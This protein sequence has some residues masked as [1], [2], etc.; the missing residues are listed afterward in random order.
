MYDHE[1]AKNLRRLRRKG[2]A[3]LNKCII[4]VM[5]HY[6]NFKDSDFDNIDIEMIKRKELKPTN[7]KL[8]L[9]SITN[10]KHFYSHLL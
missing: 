9:K 2:I 6:N 4:D 1:Q 10:K 5:H 3:R 7:P 8:F